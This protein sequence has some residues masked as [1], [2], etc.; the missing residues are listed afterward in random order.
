MRKSKC[1][2]A[3]FSVT[4]IRE[5]F[6]FDR[7]SK[8]QQQLDPLTASARDLASLA[9]RKGSY[10]DELMEWMEP[11]FGGEPKNKRRLRYA[12]CIVSELA[13]T[14]DPNFRA[15]WAY[16]RVLQSAVKGLTHRERIMLAMALY[17]RYQNRWKLN[18]RETDLLEN[19]DKLWA[20]CVGIAANLAFNLS[21]GKHGNLHH[22]RLLVED[23]DVRLE[24][25]EE[26]KPLRTETVEKKLDGL[27]I[28]FRALSNFDM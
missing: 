26:A 16:F 28:A 20:Q 24:L 21:G 18:R 9:G 15:E 4:G 1:H 10:A 7:L 13:W 23:F 17:H 11:L 8:G 14:I 6:L 3:V 27:G 5:G 22:A 19:S 12:L 2:Y 25:D